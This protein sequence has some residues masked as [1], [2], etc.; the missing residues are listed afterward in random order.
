MKKQLKVALIH[1]YLREYGGAERV[2]EELHRMFPQAPV[3]TAFFD[4]KSLGVQAQKFAGWKIY[5]SWLAR[6]PGHKRLY[7]PLR[8]LAPQ[9]FQAFDLNG[10]DLIISS[11]NMYFAK[12]IKKSPRAVHISYCHT[13]P[14]SLYGFST[15]T[16]WRKNSFIRWGGEVINHYLRFA[17]YGI[18]QNVDVFIANSRTVQARIKKFYRRS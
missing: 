5:Q 12:A 1:D 8:I 9:F 10:F 6:I 4:R 15:Q 16:D 14:R 7:S 18:S 11:S 13:P 2:L 3:Y 17:D